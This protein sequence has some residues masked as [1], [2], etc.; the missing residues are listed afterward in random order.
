MLDI[1][2]IRKNPKEVE[3][4][5]KKKGKTI[6]IGRL[7]DVDAKRREALGAM[8]TK[9]AEQ[10]A[11]GESIP[12]LEGDARAQAIDAQKLLKHEVKRLEEELTP[13]TEEFETLMRRIPNLPKED[14]KY[15]ESEDDNEELRRVGE[16]TTFD[17]E[18]KDYMALGEALGTVDTERA[19]KVSGARFAYLLGDIAM[20]EF[21]LMQYALHL[22]TPKGFIPALPPVM[23]RPE[24]M[25]AMGYMDNHDEEIFKLKD[26]E[27]VLVGTSEQAMGPMH[28]GENLDVQNLPLRYVAWSPCFRRE[29]GSYGK[30]A[31]GILRLHQFNKMEMFSFTTPDKSEEE[32]DFLLACQE[33][34]MQG[35]GLPYRVVR[36]CTGDMGTPSAR[37]YD[38]ETWIPSQSTYRETHSTSTTTDFQSRR[39]KITYKNPETSKRE[40]VHMLNGT[41]FAD[42]RILI[43][44]MENYQQADGTIKIPD[45][46]VP[47]MGSK[48]V[49]GK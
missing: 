23:V 44:I 42:T 33:E 20:L 25:A 17:F 39:L 4:G 28:M 27:L 47:Y 12:K 19:A 46:L 5:A 22:L 38:I 7:L 9:R 8:E 1:N 11:A 35:L 45:V 30:D 15:G 2:Y 41:A 13:I 48:A 31:R 34:I 24:T 29:A 6:D 32:H 43:A 26:D 14:V 10:N 49:I 3:E 16:P 21:A 37:T 18:P 36:Q 40:F